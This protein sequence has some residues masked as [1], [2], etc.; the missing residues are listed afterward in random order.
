MTALACPVIRHVGLAWPAWGRW[1]RR[2]WACEREY[3]GWLRSHS[4]MGRVEEGEVSCRCDA[5]AGWRCQATRSEP[6]PPSVGD[7]GGAMDGS[8]V[9]GAGGRREVFGM[10]LSREVKHHGAFTSRGSGASRVAGGR[11]RNVRLVRDMHDVAAVDGVDPDDAA[12]E[13]HVAADGM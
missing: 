5:R 12:V 4:R 13:R 11:A 7:P 1:R 8:V 10:Q 6:A 9:S 3:E 2:P